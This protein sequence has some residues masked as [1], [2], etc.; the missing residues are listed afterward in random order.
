MFQRRVGFDHSETIFSERSAFEKEKH[1][2]HHI[3]FKAEWFS[4][5]DFRTVSDADSGFF[6]KSNDEITWS[7]EDMTNL[8][9]LDDIF[10]KSFIEE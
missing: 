2:L 7:D 10:I 1:I 3:L 4:A 6:E 5:C 9:E 8:E